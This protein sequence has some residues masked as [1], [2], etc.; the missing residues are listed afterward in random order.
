MA[1]SKTM[2]IDG[3]IDAVTATLTVESAGYAAWLNRCY[4]LLE[5]SEGYGNFG[6]EWGKLGY[7][8]RKA[9]SVFVGER[10]K[11][12]ML[13]AK[14]HMS[15]IAY[16]EAYNEHIHY[17]RLDLQ[18][19]VRLPERDLEYGKARRKEATAH[20]NTIPVAR[21]RK[22]HAHDDDDGGYTV[23]VGSRLSEQFGR[24]YNKEAEDAD[25]A[26]ECCWRYEVELHNDSATRMGHILRQYGAN[27]WTACRSLVGN[28][29]VE[30]GV[31]VPWDWSDNYEIERV[32][33]KVVS[34]IHRRLE[35]LAKQVAPT[36][37]SLTAAGY[38][39]NVVS[40]LGLDA[41]GSTDAS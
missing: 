7:R 5:I 14:G 38:R 36:V 35:W 37:A 1:H 4:E 16:R 26:Y 6:K 18:I 21:R 39:D 23:Y 2:V 28:W 41:E 20:N 9:G 11:D 34:D 32:R 40:A 8:G 22:I 13:E 3:G 29:F 30:K 24:C 19:T 10:D 25:P 27:S 31:Y 15:E 17:S 12:A 33:G